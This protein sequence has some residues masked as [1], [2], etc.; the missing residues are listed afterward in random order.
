M[1]PCKLIF[2]IET[3]F[4]LV[5]FAPQ[6]ADAFG[7]WK[8]APKKTPDMIPSGALDDYK[9]YKGKPNTPDRP[10]K[11]TNIY[12]EYNV[13]ISSP[14]T[15]RQNYKRVNEYNHIKTVNPGNELQTQSSHEDDGEYQLYLVYQKLKRRGVIRSNVSFDT[16]LCD[17]LGKCNEI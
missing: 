16:F 14:V 15:S 10:I 2:A 7:F 6:S 11:K 4:F 9:V 17:W 3:L 1:Q 13:P 8:R 5:A 12:R